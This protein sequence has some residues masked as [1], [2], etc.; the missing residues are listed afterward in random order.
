MVSRFSDGT[1]SGIAQQ[2]GS[3]HVFVWGDEWIEFDSEW[4]AQV[5]VARFWVNIFGWFVN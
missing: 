3:G 1:P 5:M 4:R 2:R